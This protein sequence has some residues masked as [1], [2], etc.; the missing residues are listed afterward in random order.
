MKLALQSRGRGRY[1]RTVNLEDRYFLP[2]AGNVQN[3]WTE[4]IIDI[5]FD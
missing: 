2:D 3:I 4:D 1:G 5:L